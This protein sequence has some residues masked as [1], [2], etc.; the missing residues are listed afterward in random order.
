[1]SKDL[2]SRGIR[3]HVRCGGQATAPRQ[4]RGMFFPAG[5]GQRQARKEQQQGVKSTKERGGDGDFLQALG[6]VSQQTRAG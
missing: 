2:R 3:G 4:T 6:L 1:M 5:G